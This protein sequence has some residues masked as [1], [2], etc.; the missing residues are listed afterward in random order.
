M[1]SFSQL[2]VF[3]MIRLAIMQNQK[4]VYQNA[5]YFII[6]KFHHEDVSLYIF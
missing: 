3:V 6:D 2:M 4:P 1:L 5:L